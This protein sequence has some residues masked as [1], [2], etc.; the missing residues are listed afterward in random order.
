MKF[1]YSI[2]GI[3]ALHFILN[4]LHKK[5]SIFMICKM[6][7]V[8]IIVSDMDHS[9]Q[10]YS[11][12]FGFTLRFRGKQPDREMAFLYLESQP[13][14]E[15]ELIC[16]NKTMIEYSHHGRVNHLAFT[17]EDIDSVT[18][19]LLN[20]GIQFTSEDIKPTIDGG[21]MIMFRGPDDEL[22]Q[23]IEKGS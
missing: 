22:L 20:K 9:I 5:G 21:K 6:E 4:T 1:F 16:E 8:A 14:M 11:D 19:H 17:V 15:I 12:L 23:L 7:H 18:S 10:F 2:N 3:I 13:D